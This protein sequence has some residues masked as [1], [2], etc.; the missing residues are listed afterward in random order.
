MARWGKEDADDQCLN[1]CNAIPTSSEEP[2]GIS[3][4]YHRQ[5]KPRMTLK[6][7]P[8]VLEDLVSSGLAE[9]T[10]GN[11]WSKRY[12]WLPIITGERHE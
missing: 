4:I 5:E 12:R 11:H 2:L 8:G 6:K 9:E 1:L 10:S 7:L 3:T